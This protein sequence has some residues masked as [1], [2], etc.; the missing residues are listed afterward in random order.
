MLAEEEVKEK[1]ET[2]EE[3]TTE[4]EEVKETPEEKI[5]RLEGEKIV[6]EEDKGNQLKDAVLISVISAFAVSAGG[7]KILVRFQQNPYRSATGESYIPLIC[8][9]CYI[10]PSKKDGMG[11]GKCSRELQIAQDDT[12]NISNDKVM[13]A[14]LMTFVGRKGAIEGN[15]TVFMEPGHVI[16]VEDPVNDIRELEISPDVSG[17]MNQAEF[18]WSK[19][20]TITGHQSCCAKSR[21]DCNFGCNR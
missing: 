6:W 14:T 7:I 19:D 8:G 10:H 18:F 1:T 17:A 3:E 12:V 16:T 13:M 2:T 5:T 4:E 20:G 9:L 15:D 11:D 21:S